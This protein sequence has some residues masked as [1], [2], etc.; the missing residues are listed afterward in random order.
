MPKHQNLVSYAGI[1]K[2]NLLASIEGGC[3][4]KTYGLKLNPKE[5]YIFLCLN[6]HGVLYDMIWYDMIWYD[7][8]WYYY[9]LYHIIL[10]LF[11]MY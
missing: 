8:I 3:H 4:E 5:I 11:Y 9:I 7:M 1:S 10:F 2:S 6:D